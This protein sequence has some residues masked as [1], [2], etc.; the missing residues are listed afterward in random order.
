[1]SNVL[2]VVYSLIGLLFVGGLGALMAMFAFVQVTARIAVW[3]DVQKAFTERR[4]LA[5]EVLSLKT[6]VDM[7]SSGTQDLNK[8]LMEAVKVNDPSPE[9]R[10]KATL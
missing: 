5:V 9:A 4:D 10:I 1:M 3:I 6:T 2:D 8:P 7:L